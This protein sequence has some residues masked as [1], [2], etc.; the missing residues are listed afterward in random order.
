MTASARDRPTREMI[1]DMSNDR[2]DRYHIDAPSGLRLIS[3]DVAA[4]LSR[5]TS[6][7]A[8]RFDRTETSK[9][10]ASSLYVRGGDKWWSA[11][12]QE[13]SIK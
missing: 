9:V 8:A 10:L 12:Y 6:R 13:T 5:L 4:V 11:L 1:D 2:L 3:P 7:G